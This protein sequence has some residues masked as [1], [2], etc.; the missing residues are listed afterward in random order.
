[1]RRAWRTAALAFGEG[2]PVVRDPRLRECDYGQLTRASARQIDELRLVA[3]ESPFPGG[4]SYVEA[5][6]RVAACLEDLRRG[7]PA[8][9]VLIIGHRATLH[10]LDHLLNGIPLGDAVSRPFAWQPGWRYQLTSR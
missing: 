2:I 10:A 4:E 5:T 3:L 6:A 1:L 7:W 9:W 8:G